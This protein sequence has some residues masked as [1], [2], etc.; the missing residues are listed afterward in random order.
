MDLNEEKLE[1]IKKILSVSD[2]RIIEQLKSVLEMSDQQ[3]KGQ[4][5]RGAFY[6]QGTKDTELTG[7]NSMHY[8]EFM[9]KYQDIIKKKKE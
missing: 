1:L 4:Q 7:G 8:A 6:P 9:Q 3:K 5:A 2:T